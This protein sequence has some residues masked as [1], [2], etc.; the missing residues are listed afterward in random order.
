MSVTP[1]GFTVAMTERLDSAI[2]AVAVTQDG[3]FTDEQALEVGFTRR[4]IR[5][6][7]RSGE[8]VLIDRGVSREAGTPPTL[9][10]R[11]FAACRATAGVASHLTA[12]FLWGWVS[13]GR[14]IEVTAPR[15]RTSLQPD[16]VCHA[17]TDLTPSD[18]TDLG[19]LTVTTPT[20]TLVD[21]GA[22]VGAGAVERMVERALAR[23]QV[24]YAS[25]WAELLSV[26]RS[27]R[28]GVGPLREVLERRPVGAAAAASDLE[29]R[30]I[31]VLRRHGL[32]DPVRQHHVFLG[33]RS[34]FLDL[35]Y[36]EVK[37][38]IEIDGFDAHS[39]LPA[40]EKDRA[41]QNLLV[42]DGWI[43]LRFT[44]QMLW[45]YP[46]AVAAAVSDAL[47]SRSDLSGHSR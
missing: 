13:S 41:R 5:G 16:V 6:R 15:S 25:V 47:C 4:Q 42:L 35:A 22:T 14:I 12:A 46:A 24:T 29:T 1:S 30:C 40:F 27:G 7:R 2:G 26:A 33:G 19:P 44:R 21:V 8:W 45:N 34:I 32:P 37:I 18:L 3:A 39:G 31:Q 10:M 28:N 23:G 36:P 17:S 9:R 43:V 38:A 11:V 20:R